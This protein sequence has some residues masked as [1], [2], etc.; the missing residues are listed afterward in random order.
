[1]PPLDTLAVYGASDYAVT[2][3]GGDFT[4]HI[5]VGVDPEGHMYVLDLWR[6]QAASDEWVEAFCSLVKQWKPREWAEEKG[7]IK[8]GVGPFLERM[9][10][11][12]QAF[13]YRRDFPVRGDKS[14]RA[15]S[16]RGRMAVDGLYVHQDAPWFATLRSEL[17]S[18]PAG[19]HDDIVDA[20]G[21]I[22]QLLDTIMA[23]N[24]PDVP[25]NPQQDSGYRTLSLEHGS[26]NEWLVY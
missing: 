3:D 16:I 8:A 26:L 19:R 18:F 17:L 7:Q 6:K 15:Q 24:K 21:L 22:G 12:R 2:A 23:G 1:V 5:V 25:K 9:Q 10:R 4:V 20:L 14:V 13:V 11:E